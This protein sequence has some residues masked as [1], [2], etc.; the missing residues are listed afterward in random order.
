MV[1]GIKPYRFSGEL[2]EVAIKNRTSF[3]EMFS[4]ELRT[5]SF[6]LDMV[7]VSTKIIQPSLEEGNI[8]IGEKDFLDTYIYASLLGTQE[9]YIQFLSK[10]MIVPDIYFVLDISAEEAIKRIHS[11]HIYE[12]KEIAP[13]EDYNIAKKARKKFLDYGSKHKNC[14]LID[15]MQ[16]KQTVH[17]QVMKA[18]YDLLYYEEIVDK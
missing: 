9:T 10:S 8:I 7:D 1:H 16:D 6:V 12:Q 14:I 15:G 17:E 11:R 13:K 2:K 5:M 18:C 4:D 3:Y